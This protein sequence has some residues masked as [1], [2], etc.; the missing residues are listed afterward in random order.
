MFLRFLVPLSLLT[1]AGPA[2]AQQARSVFDA[3]TVVLDR[4][5]APFRRLADF[6][7]DGDL[8]A[9]GV[10]LRSDGKAYR[11]VVYQNVGG[12]F[13][14]WSGAGSIYE[15]ATSPGGTTLLVEVGNL[16]ADPRPDICL[17]LGDQRHDRLRTG[18][19]LSPVY[20]LYAPVTLPAPARAIALAELDGDGIDDFLWMDDASLHLQTSGGPSTSIA[21]SGTKHALRVLPLDGPFGSDV[22]VA[23]VDD[24]VRIFY[25]HPATGLVAGPVFATGV[26]MAMVDTGDIDGDGDID[27]VAFGMSHYRVLRRLTSQ[28]WSLEDELVGGPAEFL[29]DVDGDGDLDGVCCGGGGGGSYPKWSTFTQPSNFQLSLNDGTGTF[30][31]AFAI[32][33][34]GSPQFGGATDVDLDGDIDLVAGRCIYYADGPVGPLRT[35]VGPPCSGTRDL[36]DCDGD[37]DVDV[38]FSVQSVYSNDGTGEFALRSTG[39]RAPDGTSF[40]GPGY[41]GDFDDDGDVDLVVEVG[42]TAPGAARAGSVPFRGSNR[43][44]A[45]LSNDGQGGL[46]D[47]VPA[48]RL[49]VGFAIDDRGEPEHSLLVDIDADGDL[50]V[51]TRSVGFQEFVP[52]G[53]T[54]LWANSGTGF[55]RFGGSLDGYRALWAGDVGLDGK[56]DLIACGSGYGG[57]STYLLRGTTPVPGQLPTFNWAGPVWHQDIDDGIWATDFD[58]NGYPDFALA[59]QNWTTSPW[60]PH[61]YSSAPLI[62]DN[63]ID[64]GGTFAEHSGLSDIYGYE[65]DLVLH[66]QL[67]IGD[68]QGDSGCDALIGPLEDELVD[69]CD[70]HFQIGSSL[71][72]DWSYQLV[73][74]GLLVDLDGDGDLDVL[75]EKIAFNRTSP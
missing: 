36:S 9:V 70:L 62:L 50:D 45:L 16:D 66:F 19:P 74:P 39:A 75:G 41:P 15:F 7:L 6:D 5:E 35:E 2:P 59:G 63:Q 57:S 64:T 42:P 33:G 25:G 10:D 23:H 65:P 56:V 18:R 14:G 44:M 52:S 37:G 51:L 29:R 54:R 32:P 71:N 27:A 53:E 43:S 61:L 72:F 38:G 21:V 28:D 49:G 24:D 58:R 22:I 55:F 20:N 26:P 47:P 11:F 68:L 34:V 3:A 8:D 30:P 1:L 46:A 17:V 4:G 69:I 12:E 40:R 67:S 31:P 73:S 60:P 13:V 48:S